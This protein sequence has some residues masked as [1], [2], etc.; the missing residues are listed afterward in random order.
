MRGVVVT[1]MVQSI[2]S[3]IQILC[4]VIYQVFLFLDGGGGGGGGGG[5]V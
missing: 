4:G 1:K 5:A 2:S 3:F